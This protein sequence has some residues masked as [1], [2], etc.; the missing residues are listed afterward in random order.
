MRVAVTLEQCWHT[1]PGGTAVA[2]LETV[3]RLDPVVELIGVAARH[4]ERAPRPWQPP[5]EVRHLGLS[6]PMLYESWHAFRRPRVEAATGVVDL[7]HATTLIIPGHRAPLVVTVHDLAWRHEHTR[8]SRRGVRFFERGL[9]LARR[10]ARLVLCSSLT[11][12]RECVDTGFDRDRLRLVPLGVDA[13]R[14]TA[15]AVTTVR[16]S[17]ALPDRFVLFVGTLEPRKNL[18]GLAAAMQLL[19][20][21]DLVVAGPDGW[22]TNAAVDLAP[23]GG[24]ARRLG[25]VPP[26]ALGALYA[27]AGVVCLPS[28]WEGF[29]LPIV[30]AMAQ[31]TPVVTSVGGAT[32]EV[33][34]GA[35]ILVEP[36]DPHAI[37]AG[38]QAA[39]E[40]RAELGEA[41]RR[42]AG[43][44]SW[45]AT[46]AATL[47]AY[48]EA[49][50]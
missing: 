8:F 42:R 48:Q 11:T 31:G 3:R 12:L 44:L 17:Y 14:A 46:A 16:H 13:T 4:R 41:G 38:I 32:E 45:E 26:D 22:K 21:L 29:G 34:G 27:A 20:G 23:L 47:R 25:F 30:E 6:R 15:D 9:A 18:A 50:S 43:E 40:R 24:R 39:I 33:A 35:A 1:V 36:A 7:V 2:A 28:Y 10:E 37:A 49:A 19:P 5:I